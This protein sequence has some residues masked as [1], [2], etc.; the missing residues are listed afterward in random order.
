MNTHELLKDIVGFLFSKKT[1]F[2]KFF[3]EQ[4]K[5]PSFAKDYEKARIKLR[6]LRS[7]V[8]AGGELGDPPIETR[9]EVEL[10]GKTFIIAVAEKRDDQ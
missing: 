7:S 4:M 1:G 5:H 8:A 9:C 6:N 10:D 3:D 2:D